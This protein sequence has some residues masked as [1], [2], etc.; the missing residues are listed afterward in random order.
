M[1]KTPFGE[2]YSKETCGGIQSHP[3]TTS[4]RLDTKDTICIVKR[5]LSHESQECMRQSSQIAIAS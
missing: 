3:T 5:Q 4:R 2:E 1:H